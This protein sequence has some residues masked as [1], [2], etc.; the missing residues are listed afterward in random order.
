M[1]VMNAN[2]QMLKQSTLVSSSEWMIEKQMKQKDLNPSVAKFCAGLLVYRLKEKTNDDWE[3]LQQNGRE[4]F[5]W[6]AQTQQRN[7]TMTL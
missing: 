2:A 6:L 3:I 5:L 4:Y 7:K 1:K